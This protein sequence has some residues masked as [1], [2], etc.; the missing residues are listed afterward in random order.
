MQ[1]QILYSGL[2]IQCCHSGGLGCDCRSDLI[3]GLGTQNAWGWP[4]KGKKKKKKGVNM[5][6]LL[7]TRG[8][9]PVCCPPT[10]TVF[11]NCLFIKRNYSLA[12]IFR[13]SHFRNIRKWQTS[14][15]LN[16]KKFFTFQNHFAL[17]S[18][19]PSSAPQ[20]LLWNHT[21]CRNLIMSSFLV[22]PQQTEKKPHLPGI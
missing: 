15:E 2:R 21:F 4:R 9:Y 7:H 8:L 13:V 10:P 11:V 14:M 19:Q 12:Q 1:V 3:P 17:W 5:F 6:P 18:Y 22:Q 16:P 20:N